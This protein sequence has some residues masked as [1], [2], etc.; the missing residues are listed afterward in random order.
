MRD[1]IDSIWR[2]SGFRVF[3]LQETISLYQ[4]DPNARFNGLPVRRL[5]GHGRDSGGPVD[6]AIRV[7]ALFWPFAITALAAGFAGAVRGD[8]WTATKKA[9]VRALRRLFE[10]NVRTVDIVMVPTKPDEIGVSGAMPITKMPTMA[11][12]TRGAE[13]DHSVSV[14]WARSLPAD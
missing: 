6:E 9:M 8:L 1:E 3:T 10:N 13:A 5:I 14:T 2:D 4:Q 11:C 12:R 7:S